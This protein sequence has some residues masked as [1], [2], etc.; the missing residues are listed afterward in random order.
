MALTSLDSVETQR[1]ALDLL[2]A[3]VDKV[4][5]TRDVLLRVLES[6]LQSV[7]SADHAETGDLLLINKV[8]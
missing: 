7:N 2:L 6:L 3:M 4:E 8:G 5:L 1:A